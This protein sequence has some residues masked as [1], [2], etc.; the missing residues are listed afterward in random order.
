MF[1]IELPELSDPRTRVRGQLTHHQEFKVK[2]VVLALSI[3]GLAACTDA[4]APT[5][6]ARSLAPSAVILVG[7]NTVVTEAD[8]ARQAEDTP[9]TKSWVFYNRVTGTPTIANFIVGPGTPPAGVGSFQINTPDGT[10]KGTLFNFDYSGVP[11]SSVSAIA[12]DTYKTAGTAPQVASINI[13]VDV[14]GAE[15]GGFTTLVYEPIYNTS[16]AIANG[17]WQHWNA[18]DGGNGIWWSSNS[19]PSAP[20]RDTFVS[21]ATIVAANPDAVILGGVGLNQGSGNA[22]LVTSL[23]TFT[24]GVSGVSTTYDFEPY[25]TA[26]SKASCMNGGWMSVKR[27]DGSSFKNQGD[28]VSY[29]NTGK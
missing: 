12:Y 19:I 9:P 28:C 21:W 4:S 16:Q 14:N 6:P 10:A 29:L 2:K 7:G 24:F 5:S 23:D 27:A 18:Y 22:G 26:S 20:N 1:S 13:Q 25:A 11:L 15:P 3:V 17:V 8:I